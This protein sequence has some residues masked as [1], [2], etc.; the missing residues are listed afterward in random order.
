[1]LGSL[2]GKT[3]NWITGRADHV[4]EKDLQACCDATAQY[5]TDGQALTPAQ[6]RAVE[7]V[8]GQYVLGR[9]VRQATPRK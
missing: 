9:V 8:Q 3:V 5:T 1:M 7:M 6:W 4:P 2:L